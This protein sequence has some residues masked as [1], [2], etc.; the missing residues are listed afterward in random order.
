MVE[1]HKE[2]VDSFFTQF[3]QFDAARLVSHSLECMRIEPMMATAMFLYMK[4]TVDEKG[5]ISKRL[6][7][8]EK[9]VKVVL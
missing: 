7:R 1:Y 6:L 2:R 5:K 9:S 4:V 3:A 8:E